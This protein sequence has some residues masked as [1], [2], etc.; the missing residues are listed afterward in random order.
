[1]KKLRLLLIGMPVVLAVGFGGSLYISSLNSKAIER[2]SNQSAAAIINSKT[3]GII[4]RPDEKQLKE[5]IKLEE[6]R[7]LEEARIAVEEEEK[8]RLEEEARLALDKPQQSSHV[9]VQQQTKT[10]V[11]QTQKK[12]ASSVRQDIQLKYAFEYLQKVED[13]IIV[14]CNKERT[15]AGVKPLAGNEVLRQSARYKS[16][17]MLQYNYFDHNSPITGYKPWELA[18]TFGYSYTAFGENI[19]YGSGY[20]REAITAK[21]IVDSWMNSPG[22]RSNI[23]NKDF[24]RIGVGVVYSAVNKKVEATQQFSN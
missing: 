24:G 21:L 1:M 12:S 14:L 11:E 3:E 20:S 5:K 10:S 7:L 4:E 13:D 8:R 15:K 18:K 17:E 16:N 19:W 23:L 9:N 6:D 22:H 2:K